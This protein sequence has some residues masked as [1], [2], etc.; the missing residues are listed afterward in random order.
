MEIEIKCICKADRKNPHEKI[1]FIGGIKP[2]GKPWKLTERQAI[3]GIK[4]GKYEFYVKNQ[5]GKSVNVIVIDN[6]RTEYLK[7]SP[8]DEL[9]NNLLSLPNVTLGI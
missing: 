8:D 1:E 9:M 6:N 5:S 3:D 2:D 4:Q 7:T